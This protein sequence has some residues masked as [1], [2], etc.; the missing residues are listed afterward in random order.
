[1]VWFLPN[2]SAVQSFTKHEESWHVAWDR[3]MNPGVY[4]VDEHSV[5]DLVPAGLGHCVKKD[6]LVFNVDENS[7]NPVQVYPANIFNIQPT[8]EIHI[9]IVYNGG[10]YKSLL[11]KSEQDI[12]KCTNLVKAIKNNEC[13]KENQ[14][15]YLIN[16]SLEDK[17]GA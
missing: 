6:I 10:H 12:R 1:M 4:N 13:N 7:I 3:Q 9:V 14:M 5:S 8:T 11:S 16:E 2:G 15:G 17:N